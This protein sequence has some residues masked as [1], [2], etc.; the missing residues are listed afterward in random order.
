[1]LK[2]SRPTDALRLAAAAGAL[3]LFVPG[4]LALIAGLWAWLGR[5]DHHVPTVDLVS[6]DMDFV[7]SIGDA[8][9]AIASGFDGAIDAVGG[10]VDSAID[11]IG[12]SI[13]GAIDS[14]VD[15][16]GGGCGGGGDGGGGDS[17]GGGGCGGGCGGGGGD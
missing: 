11:A 4:A 12:S 10:A 8:F 2:D 13:D 16:G 5:D 14:A 17:G 3:V 15:A 9:D 7:S 6:D 1:M